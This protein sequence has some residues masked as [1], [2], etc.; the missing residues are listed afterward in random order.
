MAEHP[1]P[2]AATPR[3]L[4]PPAETRPGGVRKWQHQTV[5][6][7]EQPEVKR[8]GQGT[9]G[10]PRFAE[11]PSSS[12]TILGFAGSVIGLQEVPFNTAARV[13]ALRV[14]AR[15]AAGPVDGAFVEVWKRRQKPQGLDQLPQKGP[16]PPRLSPAELQGRIRSPRRSDGHNGHH[17]TRAASPAGSPQLRA[18]ASR[19]QSLPRR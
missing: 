13:G 18:P 15:L 12:L 17:A 16:K 5:P 3:Q 4:C 7:E 6:R 1:K 11:L 2:A 9:H 19:A 14:G 10:R 8:Q